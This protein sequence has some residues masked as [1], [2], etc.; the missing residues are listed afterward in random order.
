MRVGS[1]G[2]AGIRTPDQ[3]LRV[4]VS[5]TLGELAAERQVARAAIEQLRLSPVMFELGARPHPPRALYRSYLQQSDV[6]VGIYW[7]R[8]G[9]VAPDMEISG[10]EDEY[11]LSAG[12]PRLVYLK[13][14]APEME[15]RLA[16]LL[17]RLEAEDSMSY[18]PFSDG[19]ELEQLLLDDLSLLL[20]ERFDAALD[21]VEDTPAPSSN[22]P[23]PASPFLGRQTVLQ[24]VGA[25]LDADDVRL[26]TLTGPG[27]TGK[28]RVALEVAAARRQ[29]HPD[30]VHFVDLSA[31]RESD[32]AHAAIVR[33]LGIVPSGD[34]SPL[35]ALRASLRARRVLLLLDNFEQV[36]AAAAGIGEL[37]RHCPGVK[38]LA[39]S[40][41]A[42]RV[43]GER[44]YLVPPMSLPEGGA[45]VSIEAALASEAVR[46][47]A[48]RA[49]AAVP[50]FSV[51][52]ANVGDV[53]AICERLDGLPL[54]IELAAAR[55]NLFA[56]DELRTR[57]ETRLDVLS[58]GAR[59]LPERQQTLL[60]A[61]EWERGPV[62]RGRAGPVAGV[63]GVRRSLPRR[64]GGRGP[65]GSGAGPDRR[66]RRTGVSRG[67]EPRSQQSGRRRAAT[68]HHAANPSRVRE[69]AALG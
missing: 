42:L 15:P 61:I 18:K 64:S 53:I 2:P 3:R 17:D 43:G 36:L 13:R 6:F 38:V 48:V 14:P 24:E 52:Q 22:L 56:V 50:G 26:V 33:A 12:M 63:L 32:G 66:G 8:Y 19:A 45:G 29:E 54:A 34:G 1:A 62:G 4:F 69:P 35:D 46:L 37:L 47:F 58:G 59:D 10:L 28:T 68:V 67:Q 7:Q 25:L 65:P 41:E 40:R 21:T 30:G 9:W 44:V 55:V 60:G 16:S 39:T 57:L 27:G 51:N 23:T 49:T 5:S 20:A 11:L 31:E